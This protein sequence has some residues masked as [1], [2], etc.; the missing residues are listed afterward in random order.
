MFSSLITII[1]LV[2][3]SIIFFSLKGKRLSDVTSCNV[4]GGVGD[5][6]KRH[7]VLPPSYEE[8]MMSRI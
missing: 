2:F 3:S 5:D 8:A 4:G 1:P 6:D 7:Y